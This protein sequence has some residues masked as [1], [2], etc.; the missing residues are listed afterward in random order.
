M[1]PQGRA[2]G[3]S[4]SLPCWLHSGQRTTGSRWPSWPPGLTAGSWS[5][6]GQL[7]VICWSFCP[8]GLTAG[9]LGH[10]DILLAHG[11]PLVTHWPPGPPGPGLHSF[12]PVMVSHWSTTGQPLAHY[13]LTI[14]PLGH[15]GS[16]LAC[17]QPLAN[18]WSTTGCLSHQ[19]TLLT[20]GQ[21]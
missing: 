7:S 3:C 1:P 4:T 20:R 14:G 5:T 17:S 12:L 13:W 15:K 2:E 16:L 19:D 18:C 6:V 21:P 9:C 11:Q 8:P 10:Q